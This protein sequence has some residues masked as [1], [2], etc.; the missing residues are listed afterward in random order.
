MEATIFG[1]P[2]RPRLDLNGFFRTQFVAAKL[3]GETRTVIAPQAVFEVNLQLTATER[4]HAQFRPLDMGPD[5]GARGASKWIIDPDN[6]W[7]DNSN[8]EPERL[9]F[10]S[11]E[12]SLR[13]VS[14]WSHHNMRAPQANG[15]RPRDEGDIGAIRGAYLSGQVFLGTIDLPIIDLRHYLDKKLDMHHSFASFSSRLRLE[16]GNGHS[17]NMVVWM[18][19]YPH[20]PTPQALDAMA[21]WI[22]NIERRAPTARNYPRAVVESR[23]AA[24]VDTCLDKQ[25]RIIATGE[26]VWNG[27]WNG[28]SNGPCMARYPIF[29]SP[30]NVA[31]EPY[32][33]DVF[34]CTL[35]PVETALAKG[36]YGTAAIA[37]H[38]P[39]LKEIFPQGVCD[40]SKPDL[41]RPATL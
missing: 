22:A 35:Q 15:V 11:D 40:Y 39:R 12:R 16:A 17:D 25:G 18:S 36:L 32:T 27:E 29:Q 41:G 9:W 4:I 6:R 1:R 20:D 7:I 28:K 3:D 24:A 38:L 14:I 33:G 5:E 26:G 31:G 23:P 19:D 13:K 37:S 30:R 10:F 2:L 8:A 21:K 34:K